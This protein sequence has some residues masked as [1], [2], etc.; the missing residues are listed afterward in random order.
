GSAAAPAPVSAGRGPGPLRGPPRPQRGPRPPMECTGLPAAALYAVLGLAFFARLSW[1]LGSYPLV[2]LQTDD[3][4]WSREW[5]WTTGSADYTI[6]ACFCG[7]VLG[8]EEPWRA[9]PWCAAA[10]L[11]LGP[12]ASCYVAARRVQG[13][14]LQLE[15]CGGPCSL[16]PLIRSRDGQDAAPPK[17][18]F[19]NIMAG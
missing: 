4:E 9:L 2:P 10:L 11:G 8:T 15:S 6:T 14:P 3:A 17:G 13:L 1:T 16:Q 12:A 7:V 18:S 19:Q 5:V